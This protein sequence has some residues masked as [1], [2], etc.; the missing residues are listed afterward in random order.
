MPDFARDYSMPLLDSSVTPRAWIGTPTT[1]Q[2]H[3]DQSQNIACVLLGEREV[4]LFPPEQL[5][6]LYPGPLETAPGGAIVSLADLDNP[7]FEK[8]PGFEQALKTKTTVTLKAGDAIFIPYGWW[9]HIRAM[10]P[11]NMLVNYW[12]LSSQPRLETPYAALAIF[13]LGSYV[14]LVA[15]L[16]AAELFENRG[17]QNCLKPMSALGFIAIALMSGVP[18]VLYGQ[19]ILL[20]LIACAFGDVFLLSRKSQALFV[21]GMAAFA[22]GH[23]AYLGA[24]I[25][26]PR[27]ALSLTDIIVSGVTLFIGFGIYRWLK[28]HLPKEM[29][30]P[31]VIYF[32]IILMMV[33]H[34]LRLPTQGPLLLAMIGAVMFAVSDVFVGR[35]R[36]RVSKIS[37]SI[38]VWDTT[39]KSC[40]WPHTSCSCGAILKSPTR[41]C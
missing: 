35:D 3:M 32:V 27:D 39:F 13:T 38:G 37:T 8:H 10:S 24:F 18:S 26:V 11:L 36:R 7:D 29:R 14:I 34:A 12:F 33:I 16:T 2:I 17:A 31:V 23:L 20:G 40:L 22:I 1:V 15:A 6:N 5:P 21:V 41:I 30:R 28:P 4:T 19:L 9:H 25:T